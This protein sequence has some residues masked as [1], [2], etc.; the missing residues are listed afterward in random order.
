VQEAIFHGFARNPKMSHKNR[1]GGKE[2]RGNNCRIHCTKDF[3]K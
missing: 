1:E 2:K 3:A